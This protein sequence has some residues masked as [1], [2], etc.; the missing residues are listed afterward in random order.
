MPDKSSDAEDSDVLPI[1]STA[2]TI[3]ETVS[4]KVMYVMFFQSGTDV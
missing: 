3:N 1:G 2:K 4:K